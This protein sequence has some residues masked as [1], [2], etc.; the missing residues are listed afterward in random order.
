MIAAALAVIAAPI[1]V[2][3]TEPTTAAQGADDANKVTC[4]V[5]RE[6][7]SR[8]GGTRTCRTAAEWR[9]YHAEVRNTVQRVQNQGATFCDPSGNGPRC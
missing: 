2:S 6:V 3:A 7:G 5:T 1:A 4:R 9:A 8:L